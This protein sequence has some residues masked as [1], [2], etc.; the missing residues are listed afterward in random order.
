[1]G[2]KDDYFSDEEVFAV[3]ADLEGVETLLA[4]SVHD[5]EELVGGSVL[6][7]EVASLG[8]RELDVASLVGDSAGDSLHSLITELSVDH[9]HIEYLTDDVLAILA[10]NELCYR[11]D[12]HI[13]ELLRLLGL[14]NVI[15]LVVVVTRSTFT[16]RIISSAVVTLSFVVATRSFVVAVIGVAL[17]LFRCGLLS[18]GRLQGSLLRARLRGFL[19]LLARFLCERKEAQI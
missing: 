19:R 9:L 17:L 14:R 12:L 18:L 16:A 6:N 15:V 2:R 11:R 1:M 5:V 4:D 7:L 8:Q 3:L 13:I 10:W